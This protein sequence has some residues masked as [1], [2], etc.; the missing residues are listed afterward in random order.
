MEHSVCVTDLQAAE[1][2]SLMELV[3]EKSLDF[4]LRPR[5]DMWWLRKERLLVVDR[6]QDREGDKEGNTSDN[7][8]DSRPTPSHPKS[9]QNQN[10]NPDRHAE[11]PQ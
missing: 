11:T 8:R 7:V 5:A 1:G 4:L 9:E 3:L 10:Q 2:S 6:H